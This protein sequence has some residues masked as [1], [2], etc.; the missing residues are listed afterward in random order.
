MPLFKQ[1]RPSEMDEELRSHIAHRAD[2]LERTGLPRKEAERR[3]RIE[4][5]SY[6]HYKEGSRQATQSFTTRIVETMLQDIFFSIRQMRRAP[7]FTITTILT[8]ALGIGA[9]TAI[10][11]LINAVLIRSLPYGEPERLVYLFTPNNHLDIPP[12]VA[13]PGYADLHDIREQAHT[14]ASISAFEQDSVSVGGKGSAERVGIA[15]VDDQFFLTLKSTPEIGRAINSSDTQPGHDKVAIISHAFWLSAYAGT[16][17]IL[18]RSLTLDVTS[19]SAGSDRIHA[20]GPVTYRIIGVMPPAFSFPSITDL[21]YGNASFKSTQLWLPLVVNPANLT[22]HDINDNTVIARLQPGASVSQ[23]QSETAALMARLDKLH[24]PQ[25]QGWAALVKPFLDT[26]IG[27]VRPLMRMLLAAV[28]V[29]LFIACSNAA[30]LLLAR[31]ASRMRELGIRVALGAGQRRVIRQLLTESL[32]LGL[33]SGTLGI[34]LAFLFLR[35]L[36]LFDPGNIPRLNQASL[37]SRVLLFTLALSLLTSL[38]TGI[39]PAISISRTNL[40]AFLAGNNKVSASTRTQN[41]LITLE[42]ALV[43]VLLASAGLLLRS[44]I[45]VASV[46]TG[47]SQST[48]SM[49]YWINERYHP[50]GPG[51]SAFIKS[52]VDKLNALPGV[53][54][55]AAISNLP[56]SNSESLALFQVEGYPNRAGQLVQAWPVTPRYFAAMNIPLLAGRLFTDSDRNAY[57]IVVNQRFASTYLA[58]RN[59]IGARISTDDNHKDWRTV[60]GVV[61]D[62]HHTSLETV[63]G[64]Q[65]YTLSYDNAN[66]YMAIR[67]SLPASIAIREVRT[68]LASVDPSL[69]LTDIHTMSDL[70]SEATARRRFQTSLLTAFSAIA[71]LLALVGLYG[72]MAYT[73][74]RRTREVG[75]RMALGAQ[76]SQVVALIL[77]KA[78][79]LLAVGLLSGLAA[80]FAV[81]HILRSFLFGTSEHDPLTLFVSCTLLALC[82]LF[83]ALIPARRAASIDPMH[84]LHTE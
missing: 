26:A 41:I 60:I 75:I 69:A 30:N 18:N 70:V 15:Q 32:L 81:T 59:P 73:V 83:A 66:G 3:A 58:N 8:L 55:A 34:A 2:D 1:T 20:I 36:P 10:F 49:H 11:S 39:L 56:L 44:Y 47:F 71:L 63:P 12:E 27:P 28:L 54:A 37:D 80:S 7:G 45:N 14:Y 43:V 13:S 46:E 76:R 38:I 64:P 31:A 22:R 25:M 84:T 6:T 78:A 77:G 29:V 23:A 4:F 65:M 53:S 9:C 24:P 82:G 40:I 5:G 61:G 79:R 51:Q 74:T 42:T 50:P 19:F 72:L 17:D 67:S 57:P 52:L 35:L 33:V 21:P 48:L 68:A 62:V 16:A